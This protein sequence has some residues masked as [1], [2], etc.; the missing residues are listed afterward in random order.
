MAPPRRCASR[1]RS[2]LPAGIA[3]VQGA[4]ERG[5]SIEVRDNGGNRIAVG[6]TNYGKA[7][8]DRLRG[9]RS[10]RIAETLGY[11][12]G[13][14]VIDRDNLVLFWRGIRGR[15]IRRCD[16]HGSS[17]VAS[18]SSVRLVAWNIRAGGGKRAAA[19]AETIARWE[20]DIVALSEYRAT[21]PSLAIAE[22][23]GSAGLE[24]QLTTASPAA[25]GVNALL[26]ASRWPLSRLRLRRAPAEKWLAARVAAPEPLAVA[27]IHIPNEVTGRKWPWLDAMLETVRAWR[28]GPGVI[29]GDTNSG[30]PVL[31][32][33]NPVFGF[34][35]A[36]WFDALDAAGWADLWRH[37]HG[38]S[39]E[40]T[41]YSPN[42]GNGFRIDQAF[43]PPAHAAAG[44]RPD[45]RA[46]LGPGPGAAR[47][48]RRTQRPRRA[49]ARPNRQR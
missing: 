5:E 3:T 27:A 6:I 36:A 28:A 24:H 21:P 32:E 48:S 14:E 4:F 23:L 18:T 38:D 20:P 31:D 1:G 7:E 49:G 16:G 40:Y 25:P 19:I 9:L 26:L 37:V 47:P 22:A 12:Y 44:S 11:T 43:D 35:Y 17:L 30:R 45:A 2:L 46:L 42:G 29:L 34:R 15:G 33:E 10:D 39:R 13:E 8:L 41:W